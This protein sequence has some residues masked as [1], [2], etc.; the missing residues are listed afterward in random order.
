LIQV[1]LIVQRLCGG[2]LITSQA[3]LTTAHCLENSLFTQVVLGAHTITRVEDTQQRFR[4]EAADYRF[5]PQYNRQTFANDIAILSLPFVAVLNEYVAVLSLPTLGT[6][7]DFAGEMAT[8]TGWG[9]TSDDGR[10]N[11]NELKS[12]QNVV[13]T[14]TVCA[15]SFGSFI[16]DSSICTST[17]GGRGPCNNDNGGP[18][19]VQSGGRHIQIGI[20]SF[21][22]N[23]GCERGIPA[24]YTRVSSFV[25]WI[26]DNQAP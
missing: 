19:T 24:V 12:A 14:N 18:L 4:I 7:N 13:I 15:S 1:S 21:N 26:I 5:H 22:S 11:S 17:A 16:F 20:K 3:V 8:V 25:Q 2:S 6:T 23:S 9:R 10:L